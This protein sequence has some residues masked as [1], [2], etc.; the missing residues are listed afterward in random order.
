MAKWLDKYD[1]PKAQNGIEGTMG[2]LTDK[3]FNYNGAWGGPSMQMGGTLQPPMAGAVQTVPM[4]QEGKSVSKTCP[5]GFVNIEGKCFD[6]ASKEYKELYDYG[7]GYMDK[8]D[9]LVSSRMNLPEIVL[10]PLSSQQFIDDYA[11][12]NWQKYAF[13]QLGKKYG[14]PEVKS[15]LEYKKKYPYNPFSK[16]RAHYS[17]NTIY[18]EN[19][20]DYMEELAHHV[21]RKG[22]TERWILNDL[23]AYIMGKDP[24]E[25]EG[26]AEHMAHSITSPKLKKEFEEYR[27]KY[28]DE[29]YRPEWMDDP[30]I[31][32]SG[33]QRAWEEYKPTEKKQMGGHVYPTTFVPQAQ[34]GEKI[35][36]R[37]EDQDIREIDAW[38]KAYTN[39]PRFAQLSQKQ[40]D[41]PEMTQK[42]RDVINKFN[43][44]KDIIRIPEGASQV[45]SDE[46]GNPKFYLSPDKGD[47]P[48]Y[49]DINA[50]EFGHIP[51]NT[52]DL[53]FPEN[54]YK[55]I[56][57]R[58]KEFVKSK[59]T[60]KTNENI[61]HDIH[62]NEVRSDKN[63]L[64]YQ[65]KKMG[66]YDATKDGDIK[67]E[68]LDKFKKSGEW[69]RLQRLYSDEDILW[70]INNVA[71]NTPT[72]ITNTTAAMGASIPGSVGF[73][74]ARTGSTPSEGPY[75]KKTLP[76]AQ[77]GYSSK[78]FEMVWKE[79]APSKK[80]TNNV[81][82]YEPSNAV[83]NAK[84][85]LAV[86]SLAGSSNPVTQY[87]A[88]IAGGTGDLYTSAR[89][90][91]DK[92][93]GKAGEDFIQ[94]A[95]GFIPYSKAIQGMKGDYFTKGAQFFN[96]WLKRAHAASDVKTLSESPKNTKLPRH[97]NGG[98][99]SFYQHGLDWTPR[100]I[101][102]NGSEIPKAQPGITEPLRGDIQTRGNQNLL[103]EIAAQ[104]TKEKKAQEAR[105]RTTI[106]ADKRTAK[107]KEKDRQA[108]ESKLKYEKEVLGKDFETPQ[109]L[110]DKNRAR[111]EHLIHLADVGSMGAG[112]VEGI[113]KLALKNVPKPTSVSSSVDDVVNTSRNLEDLKYAKDFAKQYGYDLPENLER[114]S[115]S[116]ELTNR[117][118]RGMMNRHNTFVRGV[119]TNWE[120]IGEKNPEILRH[121]E[122]KGFDLSTKEGSKS[123]AEYMATHI[124]ISTGYG[125]ASLDKNVFNQGLEALYTSNSMPTGEG[126]TY[127]QGYIVKGKKPTNFSSTNRQ[128]WITKNNPEYNIGVLPSSRKFSPQDLFHIN[129]QK[130]NLLLDQGRINNT[131]H[132]LINNYLKKSSDVKKQLRAKYNIDENT[133][134]F[135]KKFDDFDEEYQKQKE[136]LAKHAFD[137]DLDKSILKTEHNK[138]T[139]FAHYI[140]LGKPGEKIL[141]PIKSWEI[142][143]STW[144]NKSR[145]HKNVYTKKLSALEEGGVV[146]DNKGY[147]NP[148]NWG[149][150]VEIDSPNITMKGV[151]Q[152]LIGI[153]DEGDV[154]YMEPGKDYKFKGK[155]VKE[156]P[157]AKYGVNQQDEKTVQHLDQLLNFTNKP[158]AKNGWLDKY[159]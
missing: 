104:K 139:G 157:V 151:N 137:I 91:M 117:T 146:K 143:P 22:Q 156:Y 126:Y 78:P 47:W 31:R 136:L 13:D 81:E 119:S 142:T 34:K 103:T 15:Q 148:D 58:N 2:G 153:S 29:V 50:H 6:R 127:G 74:Y 92:N 43:I 53:N 52:G 154:Q 144:K 96:K 123:A 39:S 120:V 97:E 56:Q 75:A 17:D 40:G 90:A 140:H 66:I 46:K 111:A 12:E 109:Y 138:K 100:N 84:S 125:R 77:T 44:D 36:T 1:A 8:D 45:E 131:E 110:Q 76:S 33:M 48:N 24:Y 54:I 155:K 118:I 73:T 37:P 11:E 14:F 159:K 20:R 121:L 19:V 63:Q 18:G 83:K 60:G 57:S 130:L 94:G 55:E 98:S 115:Q 88:Q 99:M 145:A 71:Q 101:S 79:N 102:K 147:W 135:S 38:E 89:Y 158:K 132:E 35:G 150:V 93:W 134:I 141:E 113:G 82:R 86:A 152:D 128:D 41:S 124:P 114:I 69:N 10:K 5:P 23:P 32:K 61:E 27:D 59:E 26:T 106:G 65:L 4:A 116:D 149:K 80:S 105:T 133:D 64:L 72:N 25:I 95:L 85:T 7:I 42:R 30:E 112:L 21:N 108:Y 87:L 49:S 28:Y 9:V 70:L 122:G 62:P 107:Q 67:Q 68:Q 3:G 129:D 16:G 51:Y